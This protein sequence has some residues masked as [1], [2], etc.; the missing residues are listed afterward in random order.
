MEVTGNGCQQADPDVIELSSDEEQPTETPV[1]A[2][3]ID[4]LCLTTPDNTGSSSSSSTKKKKVK[5]KSTPVRPREDFQRHRQNQIL[6]QNPSQKYKVALNFDEVFRECAKVVENSEPK[7]DP[8]R[9]ENPMEENPRE[10]TPSKQSPMEET[11]SNQTLMDDNLCKQTPMEENP[12]EETPGKQS[13]M[14]ET[15]SNQTLMDDNLCEQTPVEENGRNENTGNDM[16]SGEISRKEYFTEEADKKETLENKTGTPIKES[17]SFETQSGDLQVKAEREPSDPPRSEILQESVKIEPAESRPETKTDSPVENSTRGTVTDETENSKETPRNE[18]PQ[19]ETP[20]Q[21]TKR[22]PKNWEPQ[23][24]EM[25]PNLQLNDER[26]P[27]G[28]PEMPQQAVKTEPPDPQI[29][30]PVENSSKGPDADRIEKSKETY[31][32]NNLQVVISET[33]RLQAS[34][35]YQKSLATKAPETSRVDSKMDSSDDSSSE[36]SSS[37]SEKKLQKAVKNGTYKL[38]LTES[39]V[40]YMLEDSE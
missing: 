15:P 35:I 4:K 23:I 25:E 20:K 21:G 26:E 2:T 33:D 40:K 5:V 8:S 3:N 36:G 39:D 32:L 24:P 10:E 1:K 12:M 30:S 38:D 19:I 28:S 9:Y 18:I 7:N 22:C 6:S 13:P 34:D 31:K 27:L 11:P 14:E 16:P 29:E 37:D 17:T